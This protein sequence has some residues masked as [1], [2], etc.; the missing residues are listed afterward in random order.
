MV[1]GWM[2]CGAR[3]L[4]L[5]WVRAPLLRVVILRAPLLRVVIL[6]VVGVG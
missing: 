3:W 4:G 1:S 6:R 2:T 5:V